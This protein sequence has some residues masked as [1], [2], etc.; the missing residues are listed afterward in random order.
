M[1]EFLLNTTD[2][3]RLYNCSFYDVGTLPLAKR[4]RLILG[5]ALAGISLI[6]EVSLT[7]YSLTSMFTVYT[8]AKLRNSL[9]F[10]TSPAWWPF[11]G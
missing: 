7:I 4:Q 1:E 5:A 3:Q 2:Y 11:G 6:E 10:S 9:S 8:S